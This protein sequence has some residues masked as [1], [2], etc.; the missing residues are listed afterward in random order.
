MAFADGRETVLK[1]IDLPHNYYYREMYLPQLTNG[2]S[3]VSWSPDGGSLVYSMQGMLWRQKVGDTTAE[4]LTDSR[5]YDYQPD[6]SP[7]GKSVVFARYIEDAV[8]LYLLDLASGEATQLTQGNAVNVEPRWSPDGRHI[9]FVSTMAMVTSVFIATMT[10]LA[11]RA[12]AHVRA[13]ETTL[14]RYYYSRFDHELSPSWSPDGNELL[15]VSNHDVRYGTGN[16]VRLPV[17]GATE[18]KLV[19]EEETT[20]RARPDW[21][22]DGRRI[23]Y[24]SY[25]GGQ[26]HQ[27]WVTTADGGAGGNPLPLTYGDYDATAP[28]WSPDGT[29]I[30]YLA[31]ESGD[32]EI[33]II[34]VPGG[35]VQKVV[36][37]QRRW[38]HPRRDAQVSVV[39]KRSRRCPHESPCKP[40]TGAAS[41]R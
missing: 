36:Q 13:R 25:L 35:A 31:N 28:R 14:T 3:A 5:G 34:D 29:R 39:V 37:Q 19:R 7:D 1:Q 22:R 23:A 21:S 11:R 30:A 24:A 2:P 40:R 18:P 10:K 6:W 9:A 16:L 41:R 17:Q 4:Q 20:W 32:T 27:I 26:W 15:F 33:R 8:Q 12:A 38:L